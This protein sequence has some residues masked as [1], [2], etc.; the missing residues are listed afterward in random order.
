M[1]D[2]DDETLPPAPPAETLLET[3]VQDHPFAALLGAAI[4]GMIL[5][6]LAF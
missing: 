1:S 5:A 2:P 6:R 4:I 3:C